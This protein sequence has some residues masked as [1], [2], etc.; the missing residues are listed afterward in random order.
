MALNPPAAYFFDTY[1]LMAVFEGTESYHSYAGPGVRI[2][3]T[4]LNLMEFAY[5]ALRKGRPRAIVERKFHDLLPYCRPLFSGLLL[6]AALFRTRHPR[7]SY[8]DCIGYRMA[9]ELNVPFLTGDDAF[10]GMEG[11]EFVR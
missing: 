10:R 5:V 8:I 11:V 1:A 2:A 9:R 6:E 7:M 3:T 4:E